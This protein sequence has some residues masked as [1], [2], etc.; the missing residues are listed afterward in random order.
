ME[1]SS[2]ITETRHSGPAT[3]DDATT[4]ASAETWATADITPKASAA[5]CKTT[6]APSTAA[7]SHEAA[8]SAAAT[9]NEASSASAAT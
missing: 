7:T 3:A 8:A 9:P 5:A 4:V 1:M 2:P 6:T